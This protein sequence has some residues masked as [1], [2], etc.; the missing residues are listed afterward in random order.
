VVCADGR[1]ERAIEQLH[2]A[3]VMLSM[4]APPPGGLGG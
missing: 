2:I 3:R 4:T 1:R